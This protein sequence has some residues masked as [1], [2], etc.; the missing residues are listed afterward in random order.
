MTTPPSDPTLDRLN[1]CSRD[2]FVAA[3]GGVFERSPWVAE[4][5]AG[6][7]PFDSRAALHDAMVDV[8]RHASPS[9]QIELLC[10]HPDL[11]ARLGR[12]S[13]LTPASREEQA[14]AGLDRLEEAMQVRF[15]ELNASYRARFGFPFIIA[16]KGLD[17]ASIMAAFEAR[18]GNPAAVERETAL[19][20]VAKIARYR[21]D[22][23]PEDP[24]GA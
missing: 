3:L 11:A 12:A 7:R 5:V 16:V 15:L 24:W 4:A 14:G 2:R 1:T 18:L 8:V 23:L 10:A 17:A 19:A 20:E 13:A 9:E 21:V 22:S 6:G